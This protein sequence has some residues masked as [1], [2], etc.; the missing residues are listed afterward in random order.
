MFLFCYLGVTQHQEERLQNLRQRGWQHHAEERKQNALAYELA[1]MP[2][3]AVAGVLR[4]VV[5]GAE[6]S[7]DEAIVE[8]RR[9]VLATS[10]TRDQLEG[11]RAFLE[12]RKPQFNKGNAP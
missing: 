4:A 11:M 1:A 3:I 8:E 9:A 10:G 12:K 5:R 7:F 2:S 6:L